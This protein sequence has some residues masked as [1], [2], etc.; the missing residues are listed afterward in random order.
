M[1]FRR[2]RDFQGA[3]PRPEAPEIPVPQ[4]S[5]SEGTEALPGGSSRSLH[6][7]LTQVLPLT[8][9]IDIEWLLVLDPT[10]EVGRAE[11][12]TIRRLKSVRAAT[13]WPDDD[14]FDNPGWRKTE[15]A[16]QIEDESDS[17]DATHVGDGKPCKFYNHT[18]CRYGK[19]CRRAHAGDSKSV[20]DE[21]CVPLFCFMRS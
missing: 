15:V 18:K 17:E 2:E 20:R 19:R 7:S 10:N 11:R 14:E 16:L 12:E 13:N 9:H 21:L 3:P 8:H 1:G 4:S 6:L 5:C